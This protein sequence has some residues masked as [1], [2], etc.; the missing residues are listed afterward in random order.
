MGERVHGDFRRQG[1]AELV[2]EGEQVPRVDLESW[3]LGY[4]AGLDHATA[5]ARIRLVAE[6]AETAAL[7]DE[8]ARVVGPVSRSRR[9]A[10]EVAE[11][12]AR[13][14]VVRQSGDWP[15]VTLPGTGDPATLP[16]R[17]RCRCPR[18]PTRC[19]ADCPVDHA[20]AGP[21]HHWPGFSAD[22]VWVDPNRPEPTREQ[23]AAS[24]RVLARWS[25]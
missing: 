3:A 5:T 6:I 4:V 13:A 2:V 7:L 14:V 1:L 24:A 12:E 20:T 15:A 10:A 18:Q 23:L 16:D 11:G 9:L 17:W 8:S 21:G 19:R 22:G 25:A